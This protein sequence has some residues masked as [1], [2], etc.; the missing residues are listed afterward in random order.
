[1]NWRGP[2]RPYRGVRQAPAVVALSLQSGDARECG[3]SS[4]VS[5]PVFA[6]TA[7]WDQKALGPNDP[8]KDIH[9][10]LRWSKVRCL[11]CFWSLPG[12]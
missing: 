3:Y 12:R 1:M 11:T 9:R 8:V 5:R 10:K 6:T 2:I 7:A 4:R